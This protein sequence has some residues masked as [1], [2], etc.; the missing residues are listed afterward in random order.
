MVARIFTSF[1][2]EVPQIFFKNQ[3]MI[4]PKHSR[5]NYS[6]K[7][8]TQSFWQ[9]TQKRD[10]NL[11]STL[12]KS[13]KTY[14]SFNRDGAQFQFCINITCTCKN[15]ISFV[16]NLFLNPSKWRQIWQNVNIFHSL[17]SDSGILNQG[18]SDS[19][20][21]NPLQLSIFIQVLSFYMFLHSGT[22]RHFK[23]KP[24]PLSLRNQKCIPLP[25]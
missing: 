1:I 19:L 11:F 20:S 6:V 13:S 2:R 16:F 12:A 7:I 3:S 10:S 9:S 14:L 25:C 21:E 4:K 17:F 22:T 18:K 24:F 5:E 23:I 15:F 8:R